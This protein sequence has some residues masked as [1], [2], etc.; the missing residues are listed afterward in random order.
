[1]SASL[2]QI[3]HLKK[4]WAPSLNPTANPYCYWDLGSGPVECRGMAAVLYWGIS[5]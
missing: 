4:V 5:H 1:M 2:I 3:R